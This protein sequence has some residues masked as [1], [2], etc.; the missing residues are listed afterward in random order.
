M[1]L[2]K[3]RAL[4][5][6]ASKAAVPRS[7]P[8]FGQMVKGAHSWHTDHMFE[9]SFIELYLTMSESGEDASGARG[10]APK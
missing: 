5:E 2:S 1:Q 6:A 10:A 8:P 9:R 4:E 7:V 3:V